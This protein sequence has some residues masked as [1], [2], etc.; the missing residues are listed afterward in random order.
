MTE[1]NI[2]N[3]IKKL[4]ALANSSNE[5]EAK[6]A[7]VKAQVLILRYNI[8]EARVKGKPQDPWFMMTRL[9]KRIPVVVKFI[10]EPVMTAALVEIA[11]RSSRTPNGR[12][13][14]IFGRES[15]VKMAVFLYDYLM[16]IFVE[17]WKKYQQ[18][19]GAERKYQQSFFWGLNQGLMDKL[20]Q[21]KQQITDE[22]PENC[23]AI[24]KSSSEVQ[25]EF[26]KRF[27]QGPF[28]V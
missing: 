28:S 2:I 9:Y 14:I 3:K 10:A 12:K 19:T 22:S 13:I 11:S 8:A 16:R 20:Q 24:V 1:E 21:Q 4:L 5:H 25:S 15:N 7:A 17:L 23:A 26:E 27:H 18:K 6:A